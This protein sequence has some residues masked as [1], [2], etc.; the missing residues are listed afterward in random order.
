LGGGGDDTFKLLNK[1]VLTV[2]LIEGGLGS[3]TLTFSQDG[4]SIT[5]E[6]F[7]NIAGVEAIQTKDGTNY[8]NLGA[9]AAGS[10]LATLVGGTGSDTIDASAFTAAITIDSGDGA[11][12]ITGSATD[13]NRIL[14]GAGND[15]ITLVGGAVG[16]ATLAGG[17]GTDTLS[18]AA[19]ATLT[20]A[21]F[22]TNI[23]DIEVLRAAS[24]GASSLTV[25]LKAQAGGIRTVI[26]GDAND[27][28]DAGKFTTGMTLNGG[29]GD[30]SLVV[31]TGALLGQSSILG[32]TGTD[33][34]SFAVDALSVTDADFDDVSSIELLK[35]ASGNNR[36]VVGANAQAAGLQT[37]LGGSG[38]DT[39]NASAFTTGLT[40]DG[41]S[42]SNSLLGGTGN[43]YYIINSSNDVVVDA[44]GIDT[45]DT[46]ATNTTLA[47]NIENLIF[48]GSGDATLTGNSLANSLRGNTGSQTLVGAGGDDTLDGGAGADSLYGGAGNN[49]YVIDNA[50]DVIANEIGG[51]DSVLSQ[52]E[53]Y[54]LAADIENLALGTGIVSGTGN[55]LAN[56]L[57]GNSVGN[58]LDGG[59]GIDSLVGRVGNET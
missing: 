40:L 25:G 59:A 15:A 17:L 11:D 24:S 37:L 19:N 56:T 52:L 30:D 7:G 38:N 8:V 55:S 2:S 23:T 29:Q 16:S 26:G 27:I 48:S 54:T 32:G 9:T 35:T 44:G 51:T 36:V 58:S 14:A 6:N 21:D 39:L 10:G 4:L 57:T 34:L 47:S 50:G 43:D 42:G 46:Q 20:D 41:G 13:A 1:N 28:L 49:L 18:L 33:T 5:D 53:N 22:G 31:S 3:D 45:Y 12:F